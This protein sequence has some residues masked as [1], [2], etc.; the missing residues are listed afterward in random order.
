MLIVFIKFIKIFNNIAFKKSNLKKPIKS[1]R[2][3]DLWGDPGT[4]GGK[5]KIYSLQW[6]LSKMC[7]FKLSFIDII[8]RVHY[9]VWKRKIRQKET[10]HLEQILSLLSCSEL[11]EVIPSNCWPA[12]Q[13]DILSSYFESI[14]FIII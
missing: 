12:N 7:S 3:R 5:V 9:Q 10:P 13:K 11:R 1:G 14:C 8:K 6:E 2:S 4:L